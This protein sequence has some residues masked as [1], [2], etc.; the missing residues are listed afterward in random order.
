MSRL[1]D[2][3]G[4]L[5]PTTALQREQA[6]RARRALQSY[7]I[8][9]DS[10]LRARIR[11]QGSGNAI[12]DRIGTRV[13][14]YARHV[15]RNA[16]LGESV[17]RHLAH[18]TMSCTIWPMVRTP[19]GELVED[20]NQ[21]LAQAWEDWTPRAD[22]SATVPWDQVCMQAGRAWVRDGEAFGHMILGSA[23]YPYPTDIPLAVNVLESDYLD[24]DFTVHGRQRIIQSVELGAGQRVAAWHVYREHPGDQYYRPAGMTR[25]RLP[26]DQVLALRHLPRAGMLRGVSQLAAVLPT[27]EDL[28]EYLDAERTAAK[29]AACFGVAITRSADFGTST[30]G[31]LSGEREFVYEPGMTP[32]LLPGESIASIGMNRPNQELGNYAT[33]LGRM[34]AVGTGGSHSTIT[35]D[36]SGTYSSQRQMMVET[37][38]YFLEQHRIAVASWHRPLWRAFVQAAVIAGRLRGLLGGIDPRTLTAADFVPVPQPWIDPQREAAADRESVEAG[39]ESRRGIIRRRGGDPRR[40]DGERASDE[41]PGQ[42]PASNAGVT[43]R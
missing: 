30:P 12:T 31:D 37:R 35:G 17:I 14:D 39:F 22:L 3:I 36:Y 26:V 1:D 28:K 25:L 16:P 11:D 23:R 40:I 20:A 38:P 7:D 34:V 43:T 33:Q 8:A 19:D 2:L 24:H 29:F 18:Q 4:W 27:I 13:R 42:A 21:A 41:Q 10:H 32:H 9:T 5:S 15:E 6:R